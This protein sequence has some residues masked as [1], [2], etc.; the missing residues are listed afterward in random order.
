MDF[1]SLPEELRQLN[2]QL[3][4]ELPPAMIPFAYVP[5][6]R[7]PLAPTGK[8]DRKKFK[9][10]GTGFTTD[11]LANFGLNSYK[12]RRSLSTAIKRQLQLL[13][14]E[15]FAVSADYIAANDDFL[16]LGGDSIF[17]MHLAGL[18]RKCVLDFNAMEVLSQSKLCDL[19]KVAQAFANGKECMMAVVAPFSM[20]Q[21]D[22]IMGYLR[23]N[24]QLFIESLRRLPCGRFSSGMHSWGTLETSCILELLLCRP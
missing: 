17:A 15:I 6:N 18:G 20:L 5:V 9:L 1:R 21:N 8:T 10:L 3:A 14:A 12:P 4:K 16:Q 23:R 24:V 2:V 13:W 22:D 11:E 19:A 7:I